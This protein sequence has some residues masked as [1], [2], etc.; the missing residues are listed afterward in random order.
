MAFGASGRCEL[1]QA[2]RC[3]ANPQADSTSYCVEERRE[4]NGGIVMRNLICG[5]LLALVIAGCS[6]GGTAPS[7]PTGPSSPMIDRVKLYFA[8]VASDDKDLFEKAKKQIGVD[9]P[10]KEEKFKNEGSDYLNKNKAAADEFGKLKEEWQSDPTKAA[11]YVKEHL[12]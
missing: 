12:K 11:A 8:A 6:R 4:R 1:R 5:A 2:P 7:S 3:L 9:T 10:E